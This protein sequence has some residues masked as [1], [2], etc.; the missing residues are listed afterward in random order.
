MKITRT[1]TKLFPMSELTSSFIARRRERLLVYRLV[2]GSVCSPLVLP[3]LELARRHA[4]RG[5][6][7]DLRPP[8]S[9]TVSVHSRQQTL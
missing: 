6:D 1:G 9:Q 4:F 2:I 3:G 7:V 5:D 8:T